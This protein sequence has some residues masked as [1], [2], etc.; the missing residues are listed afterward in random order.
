M[1]YTC[2]SFFMLFFSASLFAGDW[3]AYVTGGGTVTPL[4]LST[5]KAIEAISIGEGASCI[6]ITPNAK[7]AYVVHKEL[8]IVTPI[9]LETN[10]PASPILVDQNPTSIAIMP[11]ARVAYVVTSGSNSV[12]ILDLETDMVEAVIPV[13]PSPF[14]IAISPDGTRAYIANTG[15]DTLSVI[16][17][18][19]NAV[20][21]TF[22]AGHTVH[23]IAITPDGSTLYCVNEVTDSI[24]PIN[25]DTNILGEE[26]PVGE[27]PVGIGITH[28]GK[29]AYVVNQGD[30]TVTPLDLIKNIPGEA[31]EVGQNPS[32]IA[33][34]PDGKTAYVNNELDKTI[35]LIDIATDRRKSFIPVDRA[36]VGIVITPDQPP[37]AMYSVTQG[38]SGFPSFFDASSSYSPVGSI[39]NYE[40]DFGDGCHV[41]GTTPTITHTFALDGTFLVTL[42]LTNSAGTSVDKISTGQTMSNA[43]S[44]MAMFYEHLVIQAGEPPKRP[45]SFTATIIEIQ[46]GNSKRLKLQMEWT[47]SV[48]L[49]VVRY[50]IFEED[51]L[52]ASIFQ[53]SPLVFSKH[54]KKSESFV[55]LLE[56]KYQI[57]SVSA[58][59]AVSPFRRLKIKSS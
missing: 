21:S 48:T 17:T 24:T 39:V 50:E 12:T 18:T 45:A 28:D 49:S 34:S 7:K 3:V 11:N 13:G 20:E 9:D 4:N 15:D 58:T 19:N 16:D 52:I 46:D 40:W 47:H 5:G 54:I 43:G 55:K 29:K 33:I 35:T 26:I 38:L 10:I 37:V 23:A 44:S 59:G 2:F 27:F 8:A 42:I 31:I 41:I 53:N 14:C 57:R 36:P 25:T 32:G 22:S 6:A 56:K 1:K 30:D 51:Q